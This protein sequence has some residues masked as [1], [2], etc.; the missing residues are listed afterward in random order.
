VI[1]LFLKATDDPVSPP[2]VLP[3]APVMVEREDPRD[4]TR[5]DV[6]LDGG[7]RG[8]DGLASD[9]RP[10]LPDDDARRAGPA[11]ERKR[12]RQALALV[13]KRAAGRG[14]AA[15]EPLRGSEAEWTLRSEIE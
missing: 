1:E 4:L 10:V 2:D 6:R 5:D 8:T 7:S 11:V 9:D 3:A 14:E 12:H 15:E 13:R